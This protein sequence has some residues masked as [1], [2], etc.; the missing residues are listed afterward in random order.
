M[1]SG[2]RVSAVV[3][4]P[5]AS[6]Q[7]Q[8]GSRPWVRASSPPAMTTSSKV[9]QP[10]HC[11]TLS[12]VGTAEAR[13]PEQAAQQHHRRGPGAGAEH[14]GGAQDE[15]AK[16][17]ADDRGGQGAGERQRGQPGR[18]AHRHGSAEPEQTDAQV[19]PE[20][21]LV[22]E[23]QGARCRLVEGQRR[24]G[25]LDDVGKPLPAGPGRSAAPGGPEGSDWPEGPDGR[26]DRT[27]RRRPSPWRHH[28]PFAG[29]NRIRFE[30]S[31]APG[32][33]PSHPLSPLVRAPAQVRGSLAW[34]AVD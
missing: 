6:D 20:P 22:E 19:A 25:A 3:T 26:R 31:V 30:R 16:D 11:A 1:P 7:G 8:R 32:R 2:R 10:R 12:D 34:A 27:G 5:A 9:P 14:Q 13:A 4:A 28:A 33:I 29:T 18:C 15:G 24:L 23:G 17:G 21:E